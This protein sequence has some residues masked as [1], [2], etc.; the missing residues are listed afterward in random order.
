[1]PTVRADGST[2]EVMRGS[3]AVLTTKTVD[4][5]PKVSEDAISSTFC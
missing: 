3:T 4:A 2:T 1:M 5:M